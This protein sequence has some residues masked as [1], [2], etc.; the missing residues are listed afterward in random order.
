MVKLRCD[1]P[2]CDF[3][4]KELSWVEVQVTAT[5]DYNEKESV[6]DIPV[7][8]TGEYVLACPYCGAT[9]EEP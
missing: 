5:A 3:Y 9:L 2:D 4:G 8:N 7:L 6:Y 1:R